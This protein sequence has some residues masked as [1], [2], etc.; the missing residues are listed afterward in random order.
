[1]LHQPPVLILDEPTVGL[2]PVLRK[3]IWEELN[4]LSQKGTTIVVTTHVM[5]EAER[6]HRLGMIREGKLVAV[7]TPEALKRQA[8]AQTLEEAFVKLGSDSV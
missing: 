2:D 6:C 3:A 8:Q 5:D 4:R 1:M 7:G